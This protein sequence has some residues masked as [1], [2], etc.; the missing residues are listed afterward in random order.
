MPDDEAH[1]TVQ[2]IANRQRSFTAPF[3]ASP[4]PGPATGSVPDPR[5]WLPQFD[6]LPPRRHNPAA[7]EPASTWVPSP[8]RAA[9]AALGFVTRQEQR[10]HPQLFTSPGVQEQ[11]AVPSVV[12]LQARA[13]T[14]VSA[15]AT[16]A[17]PTSAPDPQ[18]LH[19]EMHRR[20]Q[21]VEVE[22]QKLRSRGVGIGHNN[23]PEPFGDDDRR[24]VEVAIVVLSAQS[25]KPEA[26]PVEAGDAAAKL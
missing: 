19:A 25:P 9:A 16:I 26:P 1:E 18:T 15:R 8:P 14:T 23:P 3:V 20:I 13:T 7:L 17:D 4:E 22:L 2:E 6:E 12:Q 21:S 11:P 24:A 10:D 5:T